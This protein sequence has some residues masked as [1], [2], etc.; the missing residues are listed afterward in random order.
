MEA[1]ATLAKSKGNSSKAVAVGGVSGTW[2]EEANNV[3]DVCRRELFSWGRGG[4]CR[5]NCAPENRYIV[6][7][8]GNESG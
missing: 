1:V 4:Q 5:D 2:R 7:S 3:G 8:P 6:G